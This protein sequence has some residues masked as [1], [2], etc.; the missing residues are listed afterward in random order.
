MTSLF[1][2]ASALALAMVMFC[3]WAPR[4]EARALA[5]EKAPAELLAIDAL[6]VPNQEAIIKVKVGRKDRKTFPVSGEPL[7]L[8]SEGKVLGRAVTDAKGLADFHVTPRAKGAVSLTIQTAVSAQVTAGG[9]VTLAA[10]E[11]RN[12]VLAVEV[13]A[14]E[15]DVT[16]HEPAA[17][18]ADELGKL[19]LFYYHLLYVVWA[20]D[21]VFDEFQISTATRR[22]LGAH[23]FP[24]GYILVVSP[25]DGAFGSKLDHLRAIGWSGLKTGVGR[26]RPFAETFLQRRLEAVVVPEPAKGDQLRKAKV[27]KEWKEVR[28]KL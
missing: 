19:T 3:L 23:R 8:L 20:P 5:E 18:A 6:V 13:S 21:P 4:P 22:W 26:S 15:K 27:A 11:H 1:N 14:L 2:R 16:T 7:E 28:R 12:P 17:D 10:W 24:A 9:S 25:A